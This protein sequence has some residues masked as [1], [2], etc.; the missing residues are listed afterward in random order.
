MEPRDNSVLLVHLSIRR[1]K[2]RVRRGC[3]EK[4]GLQ[5]KK[6]FGSE[7]RILL[8]S[9]NLICKTVVVIPASLG[10]CEDETWKP[11]ESVTFSTIR[12]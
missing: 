2:T 12:S 10:F 1:A 4:P 7:L 5:R 6:D 9:S 11:C 3:V 8:T